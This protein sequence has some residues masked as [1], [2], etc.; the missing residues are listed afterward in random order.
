MALSKKQGG[1]LLGAVAVIAVAGVAVGI[2]LSGAR[3][4][5]S[6]TATEE[7]VAQKVQF[8]LTSKNVEGRPHID[9]VPEAV[10][11]L[12]ESGFSPIEAGKLT[13]VGTAGA[14]GAPLG[15]TASDD[16]TTR[17]GS[18]ADF[19]ALIAQGLGLEYQQAVTSWADWPLGIQS[20]KYD[21][22]TSNV[23]V[24]DERKEVYDF[25]T[26]RVDLLGFYVKA[27]SPIEK[28]DG[29]DDISGLKIVVGSGT[30]QEEVLLA[31]NKELE[32][33][34]KAPAELV[35][36]DDDSAATLAI[37]SG[38]ADA[39]FGPNA[40][41]SF[42][43]KSTGETKLVGTVNGGWPLTAEIAAATKK[44]NGLIKAVNIV[45][46]KAIEDGQYQQILQRWGLEAESVESSQIN[47]PGLPKKSK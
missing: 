40:T 4:S 31:W 28:I 42:K 22:V 23:T 24:T 7:Q 14:G 27:D 37:Q 3:G 39:T 10:A 6:D 45:L 33:K 30:N 21:L 47:P 13:V 5:N 32:S 16:N 12:K 35:Y 29:A 26:Y 9:P 19:G 2:G 41:G 8:D 18:E 46:N 36:Y 1:V 38:R 15:V 11:A 25:A 43:A 34:G 44:D 20:G 17:I